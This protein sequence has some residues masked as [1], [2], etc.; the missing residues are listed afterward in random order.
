MGNIHTRRRND[1]AG[2]CVLYI[3]PKNSQALRSRVQPWPYLY[4]HGTPN[5]VARIKFMSRSMLDIGHC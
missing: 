5:Q 3:I 4:E 1:V 2:K